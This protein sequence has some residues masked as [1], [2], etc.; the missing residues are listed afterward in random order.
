M[1]FS[2]L[3]YSALATGFFVLCLMLAFRPITVETPQKYMDGRHLYVSGSIWLSGQ[4]PY[5]HELYQAVWAEKMAGEAYR[6]VL[7]GAQGGDAAHLYPP[8]LGLLTMPAALF[9]QWQHAQI[10]Q[11]ALNCCAWIAVLIF[12]GL[13]ARRYG[14]EYGHPL[15]FVPLAVLLS[16]ACVVDAVSATMFLGQTSIYALVGCLG[17]VYFFSRQHWWLA[18]LCV[19][20][21]SVKPQIALLFVGFMVLQPGGW[22]LLWRSLLLG[23]AVN[24]A[25]LLWGGDLNPLPELIRSLQDYQR[26]GGPNASENLPGLRYLTGVSTVVSMVVGLLAVAAL[27]WAE[28]RRQL[29]GQSVIGCLPSADSLGLVFALT[30]LCMPLHAYDYTFVVVLLLGLTQMDKRLAV[31]FLACFLVAAR[32]SLLVKV[33]NKFTPLELS[34]ALIASLAILVLTLILL[35][36]MLWQRWQARSKSASGRLPVYRHS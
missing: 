13:L 32:D 2:S 21:A 27:A 7:Y 11:A 14:R 31:I 30:A 23:V 10:F 24:G 29:T 36:E 6:P 35:T 18:A 1:R 3:A 33:V 26:G 17:C 15:S 28:R 5:D 12:L 25:I 20:L 34:D 16:L 22:Q 19:V 4:S 8:A 9:S